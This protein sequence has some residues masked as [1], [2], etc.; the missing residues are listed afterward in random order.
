MSADRFRPVL[1]QLLA[2]SR[3]LQEAS[4]SLVATHEAFGDVV[5]AM[6]AAY[7]LTVEART[8]HDDV[9]ETVTRLEGMVLDLSKRLQDGRS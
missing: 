1:E 8:E 5:A 7:A 4:G 6:T 2:A 3:R 9:L